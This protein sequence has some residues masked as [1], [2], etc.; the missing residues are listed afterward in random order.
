MTKKKSVQRNAGIGKFVAL[1]G[2]N[3]P[4]QL[5]RKQ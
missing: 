2:E 5:L 3:I 4:K 1:C